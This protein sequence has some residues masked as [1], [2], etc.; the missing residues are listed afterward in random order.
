MS[1]LMLWTK[2]KLNNAELVVN[3][4]SEQRKKKRT[5]KKQENLKNG[6][7]QTCF[8]TALIL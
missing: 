3:L 1:V 6:K 5:T 7:F 2:C 4:Y 8:S